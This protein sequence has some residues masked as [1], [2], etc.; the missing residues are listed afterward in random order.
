MI[1]EI[2]IKQH[3]DV[4]EIQSKYDPLVVDAVKL[5]PGRQWL[6]NQKIWII[7]KDRLG[8]FI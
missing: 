2:Y 7:P 8:W 3:G 6:P 4:Y 5:V 1:P